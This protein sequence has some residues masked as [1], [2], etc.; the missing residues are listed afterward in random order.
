MTDANTLLLGSLRKCPGNSLLVADENCSDFPFDQLSS[1]TLVLSNRFDI[2]RLAERAGCKVEFSDFVFDPWPD[3]ALDTVVYRLS[4]EKAVV[5]HIANQAKRALKKEGLLVLVGG[6]Q[7]GIKT[8]AKTIGKLLDS[9]PSIEKHSNLYRVSLVN[10]SNDTPLLEDRDYTELREIFQLS[11]NP[12]LSKPGLFGWDKTD[13]GSQ[14][15]ADYLPTF[16][17]S[18][19][20]PAKTLLD[21]GCGYGYLS[22][23]AAKLLPFHITATDNCAAAIAAC[24]ANFVLHGVHGE[25]IADDAGENLSNQFDAILCNPPFHQGFDNERK[26]TEKFLG[27]CKKLLAKHGQAL[28]VVN[29][30]VPLETLAKSH[31]FHINTPINNGR[32]KL[33]VLSQG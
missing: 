5:H 30:F 29:C 19:K 24:H 16:F 17:S 7:E 25:A 26:L 33:V 10:N 15:L 27:N 12:V 21:L 1:Q 3:Q 4:K 32:F 31:F 23:S 22:L 9:A 14:L 11:D 20:T 2:A 28:F 18:F 13:Q 8:F 6:K